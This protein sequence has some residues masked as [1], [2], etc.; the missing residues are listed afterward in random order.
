MPT[1]NREKT[2][3][4]SVLAILNQTYSNF[5]LIIVNDGSTDNTLSKLNEITDQRIRIFDEVNQRQTQARRFA[6]SK[7]KGE[8]LAFCDSDD[9]W[10]PN[11][12]E[13]IINVF[14]K[15][16]SSYVFANYHV[17]G[18]SDVR[19]NTNKANVK[20][21]V[22]KHSVEIEDNLYVF[23]DLFTALLEF[24]PIFTSCQ[25]VSKDH[26]DSFGGISERINNKN[27]SSERTTSED[28]HIIRVSSLGVKS[29]F[30]DENLVQLG[31]QGDNTSSS[32]LNNLKG[33]LLILEDIKINYNLDGVKKL[34]LE[35]E[36]D[37]HIK[38][39]ALQLYYSEKFK[40][41]RTFVMIHGLFKVKI[42]TWAHVLIS[43][44]K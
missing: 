22:E 6:C 33:G 10:A 8:I 18:E 13:K 41:L 1:F 39:I 14:D 9:R 38:K 44:L 37:N 35:R 34:S 30:L 32:Y 15:S 2:I 24:Q 7:A 31:R 42:K 43:F 17:E 29:A 5:E 23:D 27:L 25:V 19:I 40:E 3:I 16:G 11:Y 20:A 26:Y 21:W 12:L 4:K 36:I 28:S